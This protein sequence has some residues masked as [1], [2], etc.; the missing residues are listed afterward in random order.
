V[1]KSWRRASSLSSPHLVG[2]D[3]SEV[4]EAL[5][6]FCFVVHEGQGEFRRE[7]Q[8]TTTPSPT[9]IE[10]QLDM[11]EIMSPQPRQP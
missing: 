8:G 9:P 10:D 2:L 3:D 11:S 1:V 6:A 7:S 5:Q 4:G